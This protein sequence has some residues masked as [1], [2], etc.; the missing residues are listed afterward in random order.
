MDAP[1]DEITFAEVDAA[2]TR[3]MAMNPPSGMELALHPD[4]CRMA[5]LWA[6][7]VVTGVQSRVRVQVDARILAAIKAWAV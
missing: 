5:N 1:V 3:C 4:A 2:L 7:M 6:E